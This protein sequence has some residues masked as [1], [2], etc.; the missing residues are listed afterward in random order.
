MIRENNTKN[1]HTMLYVIKQEGTNFLFQIYN[2]LSF[3][4]I[5]LYYKKFLVKRANLKQ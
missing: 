2:K 5:I 3:I 1:I 4:K